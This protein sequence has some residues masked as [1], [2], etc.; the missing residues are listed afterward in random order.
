MHRLIERKCER[1]RGDFTALWH[2]GGRHA[3]RAT[4]LLLE[5]FLEDGNSSPQTKQVR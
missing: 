5:T 4:P 2:V 1:K 3:P